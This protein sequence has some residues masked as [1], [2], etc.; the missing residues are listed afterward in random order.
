MLQLARTQHEA[1]VAERAERV[2]A[3]EAELINNEL[4]DQIARLTALLDRTRTA[5]RLEEA[6]GGEARALR[7][8]VDELTTKL[9]ERRRKIGMLS[10]RLSRAKSAAAASAVLG[11]HG[12]C[13]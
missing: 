9:E 3:D 1:R 10:T 13:M 11:K 8:V 5:C 4:L 6:R 7:T 2:R 12:M